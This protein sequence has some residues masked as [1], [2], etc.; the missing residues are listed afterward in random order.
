MSLNRNQPCPLGKDLAPGCPSCQKC[1]FFVSKESNTCGDYGEDVVECR[2]EKARSKIEFHV[3]SH[4]IADNLY[5]LSE[6]IINIV[7][8]EILEKE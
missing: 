8:E 6:I 3:G 5:D 4:K 7:K 1:E 2:I